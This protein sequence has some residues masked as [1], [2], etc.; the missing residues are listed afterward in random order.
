MRESINNFKGFDELN[1]IAKQEGMV[2]MR[3]DGLLKAL[4]GEVRYE[5]VVRVTSEVEV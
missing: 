3:Q 2:S 4:V 5:D 1:A